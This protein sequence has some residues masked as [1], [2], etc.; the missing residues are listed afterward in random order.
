MDEPLVD[1]ASE[2][3]ADVY[4]QLIPQIDPPYVLLGHC[5]GALLAFLT[6]RKLADKHMPLPQ[7]LFVSGCGSPAT[8]V[9][10][11]VS[12]EP[13][14]E[15]VK[16]VLLGFGTA[17][18]LVNNQSFLEMMKPIVLSDLRVFVGY[19]YEEHAPLE[20]PI[21]VI[22]EKDGTHGTLSPADAALWQ[23]ES[24]FP[25]SVRHLPRKIKEAPAEL[26]DILVPKPT[27]EQYST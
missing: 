26:A 13:S 20:I 15:D 1:N 18:A 5:M 27:H 6:A 17:A 16:K 10:G 12:A 4:R 7:R 19:V 25:V 21:T 14:D 2:L 11:K 8:L 9:A 3:A 24:V 23:K 22:L